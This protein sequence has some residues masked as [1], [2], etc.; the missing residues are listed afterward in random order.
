VRD[1]ACATILGGFL[2]FSHHFFLLP[3]AAPLLPPA[4]ASYLL[5]PHPGHINV[6][7]EHK[8]SMVEQ[9]AWPKKK[10]K[11][12][13]EY[14]QEAY[15]TLLDDAEDIIG[16]HNFGPRVHVFAQDSWV[17]GV[18]PGYLASYIVMIEY[19]L[20]PKRKGN[21]Q[22]AINY[23]A[24]PWSEGNTLK[25]VY[26]TAYSTEDIDGGD[27]VVCEFLKRGA[28]CG[29]CLLLADSQDFMY[30]DLVEIQLMAQYFG[31]IHH[32]TLLGGEIIV[33]KKGHTMLVIHGHLAIAADSR[34]KIKEKQQQRR[35][36]IVAAF[37]NLVR[38]VTGGDSDPIDTTTVDS[39]GEEATI[40]SE[41]DDTATV[42]STEEEAS[43]DIE[44]DDA[45]VFAGTVGEAIRHGTHGNIRFSS[46]VKRDILTPPDIDALSRTKNSMSPK[47]VFHYPHYL[48]GSSTEDN[49]QNLEKHCYEGE[50]KTKK[51]YDLDPRHPNSNRVF[52]AIS[53]TNDADVSKQR[54]NLCDV[55]EEIYRF[56]GK[57]I[58]SRR[59]SWWRQNVVT[60]VPMISSDT[61][62]LAHMK[63][64]IREMYNKM[65]EN[66]KPDYDIFSETYHQNYR[67]GGKDRETENV[68][69]SEW[70]KTLVEGV[71]NYVWARKKKKG[72]IEYENVRSDRFENF[73][74]IH[75]LRTLFYT[76]KEKLDGWTMRALTIEEFKTKVG[77]KLEEGLKTPKEVYNRFGLILYKVTK[78]A[79]K[80]AVKGET[81][82]DE[83]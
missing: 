12:L 41:Y 83:L 81:N 74:N 50:I 36:V 16:R 19:I 76:L 27:Q 78:T 77:D 56:I 35:S 33:Y 1:R 32:R 79:V 75:V 68:K 26:S 21:H 71:D 17:P 54:Q 63:V 25:Q 20:G 28:E 47:G 65:D 52:N 55:I 37:R 39:M 69:I 8:S 23:P 4:P 11:Q 70:I 38:T 51:K 34:D 5:T 61:D 29:E 58:P 22:N 2:T 13:L 49:L 10:Y 43:G 9:F 57:M 44:F 3:L 60:K 64:C 80:K 67:I 66:D 46:A 62:L 31:F 42:D 72:E 24:I 45:A 59:W 48:G 14:A 53:N 18:R 73:P 15:N 40:V 30:I 82:E 7:R 6:K